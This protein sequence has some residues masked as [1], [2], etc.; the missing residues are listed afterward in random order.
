MS[1]PPLFPATL[2]LYAVAC[3]LYLVHVVL[4]R[5]PAPS[6]SGVARGAQVALGLACAA[7]AVDIG[8]LCAQGLHPLVS[9][10]EALSFVSWLICVS[11]LALLVVVRRQPLNVLGALVVPATLVLDLAARLVPTVES[12]RAAEAAAHAATVGPLGILHITLALV[13][14][15]LFAIA[16]GAAAVYLS[17]ER[18]LKAP[19]RSTLR[20][21]APGLATLD[22][23]SQRCLT[24][25]FP[26]FTVAVITGAVWVSRLP[27]YGLVHPRFLLT[28]LAWLVYAGLLVGRV[29]VGWRGRRAAL[30][31]LAGFA[32]TLATLLLYFMRGLGVGGGA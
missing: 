5:G 4:Q 17:E 10:R 27:G 31:T 18:R 8:W 6:S 26:L 25:G 30:L 28:A 3:T 24:L 23:I 22:S 20:R 29:T 14:V 9:A 16:A 32:G 1:M 2:A 7:H 12:G 13:G 19:R 15:A 11:F 21:G